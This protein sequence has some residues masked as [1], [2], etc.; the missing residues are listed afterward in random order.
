MPRTAKKKALIW[1]EVEPLLQGDG[2]SVA[3]VATGQTIFE[4]GAPSDSVCYLHAGTAKASVVSVGGREAVI[5]ILRRGDF[6]GEGALRGGAA[7]FATVTALTP[8]T[9]ERIETAAMRHAL[10]T[11]AEFAQLY[12][13]NVVHRNADFMEDLVDQHFHSTERR[14]ARL[15]L[16]L[17]A[18]DVGE[19]DESPKFTQAVL[20]EMVGTTRS[21]VN[22]FMNKFKR[23]GL[24][25]Y[26][27]KL[28]VKRSLSNVLQKN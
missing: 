6:F 24:I 7:R 20:A 8:C 26:N 14:L 9:V 27:G 17:A 15:L 18:N 13:R 5:M 11:Q 12:I 23:L 10:D 3:T 19:V 16:R 28:V 1:S 25:D 22:F 21:R 2:S 4:Q